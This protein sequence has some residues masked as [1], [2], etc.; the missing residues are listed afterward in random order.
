VTGTLKIRGIEREIT[1]PFQF[2]K[3]TFISRFS[4]NRLDYQVGTMKGMMKKVSNEI[5]LDFSIPVS[6]Q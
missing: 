2:E 1:I 5:K 3:S 4:V 6:E